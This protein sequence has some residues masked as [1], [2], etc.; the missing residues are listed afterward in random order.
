MLKK[1]KKII[2]SILVLLLAIP[3]QLI[4]V[5][6][7]DIGDSP[8]LERGNL[9]FYS[10]QY[11]NNGKWMYITYNI[12]NYADEN[13]T[14]R[15]AYCV[16]PDIE[17]VSWLPGGSSGYHVDLTQALSDV[18]LWRVYRNGYP[19]AT[20][21]QLGVETDDD[22]YLATK[23]AA[24]W[25]IRGR[26]LSGIRSYFRAGQTAINGQNL[27]DIQRR[28]QKVVD[29]IYNLVDKAYN[30]N[31]TPASSGIVSVNSVNGFSQDSKV[32]YYSQKYSVSSQTAMGE[33]TIRNIA[34]FPNGSYV[35]DL[36]GNAKTTFSAGEQFKVMIPKASIT[37]NISGKVYVQSRCQTYP[38]YYGAS[39]DS[40]YQSYAIMV[41]PYRDVGASATLNINAYKS[42]INIIKTDKETGEKL[43]GITFNAKYENGTN[44]GDFTTNGNGS[45]T[46]NNLR[47]GKIILTET[48]TQKH[49]IL[50][51]SKREITLG[52]DSAVDLTITND[53]KK[54]NIKVLKVDK[55]DNDV[56]LGAVEF[57]LIDSKGKVVRHLK[58]DVDGVAEEKDINTGDY[59]LRETKT[60]KEYKLALDSDVTIEWNKTFEIKVENEK[61]K[62]QIKVIK[63]DKDYNETKLENVEFQVIDKNSHI[64][65]TIKTNKNGEATTSRLPIGDYKLKEVSLG[66]NKE[67]VLNENVQTIKV[68]EDKIKSVKFENEHKKGN[69]KIYK[70]DLDN[71]K[72][73]IQDVEFEVTDQDGY[74]YYTKSN[75]E[76]IAYIE[77]IRT[78]IAT[79]K[80][81]KTNKIYKLNNEK[82]SAEIKW[83]ET[84]EITIKNEKL[85]GQIEVYKV[86]AEDK[87][88]KLEG[89]EFQVINSDNEVVETIKTDKNGYAITKRHPI[90]EY[91]LKETK[92][93]EM[94]ILND[95]VEKVNVETD[96]VSKLNITNERIKGQIKIVKTSEDDS[97]INGEKAGTP[98]KDV[99]FEIYNKDK[100]VVD[101]I[102]TDK[103]GIAITKLLDKGEYTIKE[104]KS[105]EWYLLNE[106][107]F[108]TK[109]TTH[110]E[111]VEVNITNES[112]KP[113]IDVEKDG[114]IQT[115]ASQEIKYD[116]DIK[117]TGNVPLD[118]FTWYDYLPTE[119]VKATRLVT[120]TFNQDLNYAIYYKTNKN[121][122]K[123]LRDNLNTQVNNYIDFS[124]LDLEEDEYVTEFKAEFGTVDVGFTSV[125]KP[126]LFVRVEKTVKND[127]EFVNKTKVDGY[128]KTYYVFDED[129]H[130]T[131]VYEKKIEV[132]LPRTG[133]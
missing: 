1:L 85:K 21:A 98:I 104:T 14:R 53:H 83:N 20:P 69:L 133:C 94:H 68:E 27:T 38:V 51:E 109:I 75:E 11:N 4:Q 58:T 18:R 24:Y 3:T 97:F 34:G 102:K 118:K 33:Y 93:D 131:K 101:K 106:N 90:G 126:Q 78:G 124:N 19:Y 116:F 10:V 40:R 35:A 30:G 128:N 59:I 130:P 36:N 84:T 31:Q 122:Y 15:V 42:K 110:K 65:E 71:N 2:I 72:L 66:T 120:G 82:Y 22:A 73:P 77:N 70:V 67:Y 91:K 119:Y 76:G 74:K 92:T 57:D 60:K 105:G 8:Y 129:D 46:I 63:V 96:I 54:G 80:E 117:N 13:G 121:D 12:V 89:V 64:I 50:D 16:D 32:E 25:V 23:Q 9:G 132:K 41:D 112:E 29:A 103:D 88:Y 79:I 17:G 81:T 6:A 86:D 43:S 56:T 62:G 87:E 55:D 108:A 115:T 7:M 125:I 45:I 44:I 95:K 127:D 52:Y 37:D 26:D 111:V 123:L 107:E 99:E 114:I 39:R 28:G 47:Q 48:K 113:S 49:Y 100:K 5:F 61:K